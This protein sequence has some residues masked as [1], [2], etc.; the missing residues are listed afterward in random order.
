[1]TTELFVVNENDLM[2]MVEKIM[3][4]K[5]I[6]H[7][8]VVNALNKITGII[9]NTT[10]R[11]FEHLKKSGKLTVAKDIM[12]HGVITTHTETRIKDANKIMIDN[13]I[14]CLPILD[15]GELI[16]I[17]TKSDILKFYKRNGII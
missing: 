15:G 8:P 13:N 4:W 12:E 17:I 2:E 11:K 1:M 16:G 7:I 3:E 5:K 6:H 10:L 14:G 9:T